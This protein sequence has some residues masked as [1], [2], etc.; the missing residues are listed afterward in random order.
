MIQT[1]YF[2]DLVGGAGNQAGTHGASSKRPKGLRAADRLSTIEAPRGVSLASPAEIGSNERSG[3]N[4][5]LF[6]M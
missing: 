4:T 3:M 5:H 1:L 6:V 2:P